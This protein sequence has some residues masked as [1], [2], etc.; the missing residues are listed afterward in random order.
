MMTNPIKRLNNGR[1]GKRDF[2]TQ[3]NKRARSTTKQTRYTIAFVVH[4]GRQQDS[5]LA[6]RK[7]TAK[8]EATTTFSQVQLREK[9]SYNHSEP[10]QLH[11][12]THNIF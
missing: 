4:T 10:S 11:T 3:T 7:Q 6:S 2:F 12:H 9:T 5:K 8:A 1:I